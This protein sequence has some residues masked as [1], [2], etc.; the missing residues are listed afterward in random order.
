[1]LEVNNDIENVDRY[2]GL[3]YAKEGFVLMTQRE[4]WELRACLMVTRSI[5]NMLF[6]DLL[7]PAS[8][9]FRSSVLKFGSRSIPLRYT[10]P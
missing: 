5:M 1:M 6:T 8:C 10:P 9:A 2:Q 3:R 4:N 7:A